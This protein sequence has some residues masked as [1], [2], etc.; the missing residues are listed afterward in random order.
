ME[1]MVTA[2]CIQ[3]RNVRSLAKKV[4]GSIFMGI[5]VAI[6]GFLGAARRVN[7]Q[8]NQPLFLREASGPRPAYHSS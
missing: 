8:P 5:V 2:M 3:L 7:H 1:P 4:F 6:A